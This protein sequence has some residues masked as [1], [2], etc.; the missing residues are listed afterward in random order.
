[1]DLVICCDNL[2]VPGQT[3]LASSAAEFCGGKGANQAVSAARA[4]ASVSMLGAIGDD[5]F[6]PRLR[7]NLQRNRVD[8]TNVR[9]LA[10][11]PSGLAVITV[12][13][14]GQNSIVVVPGANGLLDLAALD[15]VTDRMEQCDA[16]L[17]QLEI[18]LP[19]VLAATRLARQAGT[20]I[21]LDPAPS[22]V[23]APD[24]LFQVDLICPNESEAEAITGRKVG[25]TA[26]AEEAAKD[27][28]SRGATNVAIT[29]GEKG[30]WLSIPDF[31]DLIPSY[32]V[33]AVDTTAAGDAWA[34]A[35]ATRWCETDDLV[36]AAQFANAAG[37]LAASKE[38]AQS[39]LATRSEVEQF[40]S[41]Q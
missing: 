14:R 21:I 3:L 6:G 11:C 7:G 1:M 38:G 34:G 4:G 37:A 35:L 32:S 9:S 16:V 36:A 41:R 28:H 29:M 2:P 10:D 27:L 15:A 33:K 25:C 23:A 22:P 24:E 40:L 18:P 5:A 13:R 19:T 12:D 31:A 26:G 17:L 20:R 39:S 30:C 8:E